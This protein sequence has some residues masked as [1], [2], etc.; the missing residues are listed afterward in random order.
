MFDPRLTEEYCGLA[1]MPWSDQD[2]SGELAAM[3]VGASLWGLYNQTGEFGYEPDQARRD[4]LPI[5]LPQSAMDA[6]QL[7]VR[8]R[9]RHRVCAVANWQDVIL[10]NMLGRSASMTRPASSS[11]PTTTTRSIPTSRAAISTPRTSSTIPTIGSMRRW[12]ASATDI[13]AAARSGRSSMPTPSFARNGI[14]R[15]PMSTSMPASSSA[16]IPSPISP[17]RS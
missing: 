2:A 17:K 8:P 15:R 10:V 11:P 5:R 4:R 3:A 16:P 12:P 6:R 13:M 14:R 7:G 9:P 1:G